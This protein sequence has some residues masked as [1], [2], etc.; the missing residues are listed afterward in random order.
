[1]KRQILAWDGPA[2][3]VTGTQD[4]QSGA[5]S[6][7]DPRLGCAPRSGTLGVQDWNEPAKTVIGSGDIHAGAAAIADPRIPADNERGTWVIIS[8]DGTWHRPLTTFELA[9]L[10][11]F[12]ILLHDGTP[13]ELVGNNDAKWRER[14]GNAVPPA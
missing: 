6:I 4:I 3:T 5:Q 9:M 2:S 7:A 8:E 12:P 11:G 14:I 10:Q 13:F 1:N